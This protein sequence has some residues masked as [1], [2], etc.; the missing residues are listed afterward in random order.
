MFV[1]AYGLHK[2][3]GCIAIWSYKT[4]SYGQLDG[5]MEILSTYY[6][7]VAI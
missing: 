2:T 1:V 5:L 6:T 7:C 4:C 3:Q